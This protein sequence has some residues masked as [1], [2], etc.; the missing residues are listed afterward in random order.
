MRIREKG[1]CEIQERRTVPQE[2]KGIRNSTRVRGGGT[3]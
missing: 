1:H 3:V 2:R